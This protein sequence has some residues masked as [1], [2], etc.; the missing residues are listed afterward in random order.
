MTTLVFPWPDVLA[1]IEHAEQSP[2][3]N[4]EFTHL[5]EPEFWLPGATPDEHGF[6][7]EDQVDASK[8]QP[9][10]LL[11]K[12]AGCYLMSGGRPGWLVSEDPVQH[13]VIYAIGFDPDGDYIGGDDFVE[14]I[15]CAEIRDIAAK[16]PN[17]AIFC[18]EFSD[19]AYRFWCEEE[20]R[21]AKPH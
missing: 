4:V 5:A 16:C 9:G 7:T 8:I 21:A 10:L 2:T 13:H 3:Q 18:V 11:V 12:D 14:R 15:P 17:P 1:L 20:G 6:V 19:D